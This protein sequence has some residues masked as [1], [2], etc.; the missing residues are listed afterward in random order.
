M[1]ATV[2]TI[3]IDK[4]EEKPMYEFEVKNK[5]TKEIDYIFGY[6]FDDACRRSKLEP[7][8]WTMLGKDYI[9]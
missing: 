5:T 2:I 7:N 1:D 3:L 4:E 6:S 8:E 9:D